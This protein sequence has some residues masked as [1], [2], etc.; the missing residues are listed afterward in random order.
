M[1]PDDTGDY[2]SH[3]VIWRMP[4]YTMLQAK[5][6]LFEVDPSAYGFFPDAQSLPE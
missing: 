5:L 6:L 2:W 1:R 4:L 3:T